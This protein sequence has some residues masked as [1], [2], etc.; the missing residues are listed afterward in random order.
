MVLRC[1]ATNNIRDPILS[2]CKESPDSPNG[3]LC[4]K[5]TELAKKGPVNVLMHHQ[6]SKRFKIPFKNQVYVTIDL[7]PEK[8]KLSKPA[9]KTAIEEKKINTRNKLLQDMQQFG[10]DKLKEFHDT[11]KLNIWDN[12]KK[13]KNEYSFRYFMSK[14]IIDTLERYSSTVLG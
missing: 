2:R 8:E 3:I 9:S 10:V 5:H 13:G 7:R 6:V 14:N 4:K 12:L 1:L 11:L